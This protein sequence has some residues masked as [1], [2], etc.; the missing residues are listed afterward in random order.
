MIAVEQQERA[1][2][3]AIFQLPAEK[4]R[5]FISALMTATEHFIAPTRALHGDLV[6]AQVESADEVELEYENA[7]ISPA[8]FVLPQREAV[9]T[10]AMAEGQP[11]EVRPTADVESHIIFGIRPCDVAAIEYLDRFFMG[12]EF[13]DDVY[14]R[15]REAKTL[16]AMAC[17]HPQNDACWCTCSN[18]G[19]VAA[20]GYDLQLTLMDDVYLVESASERGDRLVEVAGGLLTEADPALTEERERRVEEAFETFE[21]RGNI[22]QAMRWISGDQTPEELWQELG[23]K[24]FSCGSCSLVCPVCSCF[25]THEY[26]EDG[27]G[28]RIRVWDSCHFPGY[29]LEA[30]GFN[31]RENEPE[32]MFHYAH[33]KLCADTF[34][35]YGRPGCVGCGRCVQVC[36]AQI[37]L[38]RIAQ[39]IRE[40]G[41]A[42]KDCKACPHAEVTA[43]GGKKGPGED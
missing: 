23:A 24:C 15:R 31:P 1:K 41:W 39:T 36:P 8:C 32:R 14:A 27:V 4:I 22:A 30:S 7:L 9:F 40:C 42:C 34:Q 5:E 3:R 11:P 10:Y 20:S 37:D 29:S 13:A 43:E 16:V 33:H 17:I 18:A 21:R 35:K 26:A 38:P 25:D 19:P 6:F 2:D 28:A 12:G